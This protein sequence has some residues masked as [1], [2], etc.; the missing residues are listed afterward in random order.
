MAVQSG[1]KERKLRKG[2]GGI[3]VTSGKIPLIM[4]T[5]YGLMMNMIQSKGML[6]HQK[7]MLITRPGRETHSHLVYGV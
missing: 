2:R 4:C 1:R 6:H 5:T 7:F 3:S